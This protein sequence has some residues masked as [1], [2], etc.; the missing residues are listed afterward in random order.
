[1]EKE[2]REMVRW[3]GEWRSEM[4]GGEVLESVAFEGRGLREVGIF[5]ELK[6]EREREEKDAGFCIFRARAKM[7]RV[8]TRRATTN[9]GVVCNH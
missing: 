8:A 1:M 7:V 2:E 9:E 3:E 5:A 6:R 4:N